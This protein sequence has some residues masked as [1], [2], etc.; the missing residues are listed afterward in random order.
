MR[1]LLFVRWAL[2]R[3]RAVAVLLVALV[4]IA[5]LQGWFVPYEPPMCK[6][7]PH[8]QACR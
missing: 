1:G 8:H 6:D 7:H 4:V 3:G 2:A 5:V